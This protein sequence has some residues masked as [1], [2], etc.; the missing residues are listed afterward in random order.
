MDF[1][2]AARETAEGGDM[3]EFLRARLDEDEQR[4]N[5]DLWIA[6]HASA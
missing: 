6:D 2:V 4:A 5:K 1:A 3:I